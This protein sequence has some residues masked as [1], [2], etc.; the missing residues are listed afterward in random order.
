[1]SCKVNQRSHG[2]V[3]NRGEAPLEAAARHKL[4]DVFDVLIEKG[5][6][7]NFLSQLDDSNLLHH[8]ANLNGSE[9]VSYLVHLGLDIN[10]LSTFSPD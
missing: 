1:M 9:W 4:N 3:D 5:A 10:Q 7:P 2:H 6:S 8:V